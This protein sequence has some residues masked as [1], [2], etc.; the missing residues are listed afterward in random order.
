MFDFDLYS[1]GNHPLANSSFIIYNL[2]FQLSL[3][4]VLF[5]D[6]WC[7]L[8]HLIEHH[9]IMTGFKLRLL[10]NKHIKFRCLQ[11]EILIQIPHIFQ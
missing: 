3:V 8:S 7:V 5:N 1:S 9:V 10:L 11:I 4:R 2:S 6:S